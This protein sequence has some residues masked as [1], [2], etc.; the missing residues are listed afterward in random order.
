MDPSQ[1]DLPTAG[2][3]FTTVVLQ[4]IGREIGP[5]ADRK[6]FGPIFPALDFQPGTGQGRCRRN[7]RHR[8][9]PRSQRAAQRA[10]AGALRLRSGGAAARAASLCRASRKPAPPSRPACGVQLPASSRAPS[11][12]T[13]EPSAAAPRAW[14]SPSTST[15][16]PPP[17][18]RSTAN[19][20]RSRPAATAPSAEQWFARYATPPPA[21]RAALESSRTFPWTS[22]PKFSWDLPMQVAGEVRQEEFVATG[23]QPKE[24]LR[25]SAELFHPIGSC[26]FATPCSPKPSRSPT[27]A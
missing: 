4:E 25:I 1:S 23:N 27:P 24:K 6:A 13:P 20:W 15:A 11:C 18:P 21:L 10:R 14:S 16:C 3:Y 17:S 26:V 8:L 19:C 12:L 7:V 22:S 5:P 2:G 9:A